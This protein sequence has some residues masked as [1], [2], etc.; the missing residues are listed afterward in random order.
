[1][2]DTAPALQSPAT[3]PQGYSFSLY[4]LVQSWG[5]N[6]ATTLWYNLL[7][8]TL[9]IP[10]GL[11]SLFSFVQGR[12]VFLAPNHPGVCSEGYNL[13]Q[14]LL[15]KYWLSATSPNRCGYKVLKKQQRVCWWRVTSDERAG[16]YSNQW[17]TI[18]PCPTSR[19]LTPPSSSTLSSGHVTKWSQPGC[20]FVCPPVPSRT[21]P[22]HPI[23]LHRLPSPLPAES[24]SRD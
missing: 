4:F 15:W 11:Q 19:P 13:Q 14:L 2:A 3:I 6:Y 9:W 10:R 23:P 24:W 18:P 22:L 12:N 7:S 20:A 5:Y 16:P 17:Q 8:T 1:M 21:R